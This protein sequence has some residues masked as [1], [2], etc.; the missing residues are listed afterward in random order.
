[1]ATE[2][3]RKDFRRLVYFSLG[4][5]GVGLVIAFLIALL[6]IDVIAPGHADDREIADDNVVITF[7]LR[8]DAKWPD[9]TPIT[10]DDVV[11]SYNAVLLNTGVGDRERDGQLV[12]DDIVL[13]CEKVDEY[14]VKFT[15]SAASKEGLNALGFD[16]TPK[17][18]LAAYIRTLDLGIPAE[19]LCEILSP[20]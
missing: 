2:N 13:L 3:S 12:P 7:Y 10:A 18:R 15:M 20:E 11:S 19:A 4:G 5:V 8:E 16:I 17:S 9:G 1:M 14:A 6:L